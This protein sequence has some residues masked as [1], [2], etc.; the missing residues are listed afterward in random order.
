MAYL[1]DLNG[2]KAVMNYEFLGIYLKDPVFFCIKVAI[3][4]LFVKFLLWLSNMISRRALKRKNSKFYDET[5]AKF[6]MRIVTTVVYILGVA[7]ILSLIPALEKIGTSILASAGILAMAVGLASQEAL[8]NIVGG[9]FII[10]AKPFRIGDFIEVDGAESG[11][12]SEITLRHTVIR[13]AENR[14]III[15]NSKISSSTIIN[16]T[17][18]EP[19]TCAFVEVGVSYNEDLNKCISVMRDEIEKPWLNILISI[20]MVVS[21]AYLTIQPVYNLFLITMG[22]GVYFL[23][24]GVNAMFS[25][26]QTRGI[27][28]YWWVG[29]LVGLAQFGLALLIAFGLPGTALYTVGLLVSVSLM[30]SGIGVISVY[31]GAGCPRIADA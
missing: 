26:F 22:I 19:A 28:K 2:I 25:A 31:T 17:V 16:S 10:F 5:S 7:S 29:L 30:L 8:S 27:F 4:I 3:I 13:N 20:L 1:I 23:L 12:V 21:G 6:I 24:E 15:P 18:G 14:M 9:I 11:T